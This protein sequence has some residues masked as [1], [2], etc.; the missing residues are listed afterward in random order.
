MKKIYFVTTNKL[1]LAIANN[2]LNKQGIEVENVAIETPEIQAF[3]SKEVVEYSAKYAF[4]KLNKP[5]IKTDVEYCIKSLCGFPG[6][7][8]KY[9]N[10]WL[11]AQEILSLMKGK[12][13][14]TMLIT[15]FLS[16]YDGKLLNTF[17]TSISCKISEKIYDDTTGTAF[18]KITV[19]KGFSKPQNLLSA[20]ELES[21]LSSQMTLWKEFAE[22]LLTKKL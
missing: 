18:D 9:I 19:R 21:L 14:R 13:N 15:E 7:Y 10:K 16:Y 2:I 8:I 20:L 22:F 1:K 12:K 6:P 17:S 5:V 11:T 4:N 3:T